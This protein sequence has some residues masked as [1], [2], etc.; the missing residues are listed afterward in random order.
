MQKRGKMDIR[1]GNNSVGLPTYKKIISID[2]RKLRSGIGKCVLGFTI[3]FIFL[4][5][6][7]WLL[8]MSLQEN[9]ATAEGIT[10]IPRQLTLSSYIE[11]FTKKGFGTALANSLITAVLSL[12]FS[13]SFGICSAYVLARKRFQ[14]K[15]RRV[16]TGWV[17][18]VRI[19]PPVAFVV[20][21]VQ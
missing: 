20:P 11:L 17:L 21:F 19:L 8:L 5:P 10:L 13:L 18:L 12:L 3:L 6:I 15:A 9:I 14:F 4:F 1:L 2:I 16:F 7:Y